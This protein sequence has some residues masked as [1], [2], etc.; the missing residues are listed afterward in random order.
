MQ[1]L[2][3]A[4][5]TDAGH[6]ESV[7]IECFLGRFDQFGMIGETEIVVRAHVEHAFAAGDGNVSVLRRGDDA[8]GLV[9]TLRFY[10]LERS[11]KLLFKF[12]EH[13]QN[14]GRATAFAQRRCRSCFIWSDLTACE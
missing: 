2:R 11:R 5:E 1:V 4:N 7:A 8:L 3:A 6:A 13:G 9:K 10:F 14:F 12:G